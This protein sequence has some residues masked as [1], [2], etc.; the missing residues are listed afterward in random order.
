MHGG[1]TTQTVPTDSYSSEFWTLDTLTWQWT[2][3]ASS[4]SGR[5]QH[6]LVSI[7]SQLLTI[8]GNNTLP[9]L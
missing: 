1:N 5:A 2:Q 8:S 9:N 3:G 4:P 7:N 6:T